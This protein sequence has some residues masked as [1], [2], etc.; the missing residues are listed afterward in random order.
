[1]ADHGLITIKDI[2]QRLGLPESSL[3][4][5]RDAF[6]Q[7][8]PSVGSGRDRRY[9]EEA[10]PVFRA[11][12]ELREERHL[13][14]EDSAAALAEQFPVNAEESAP[15]DPPDAAKPEYIAEI[16]ER[17]ARVERVLRKLI[18][19]V[20]SQHVVINAVGNELMRNK[21]D[22]Q[23]VKGIREDM[24]LMRRLL[25]ANREEDARGGKEAR[26]Q[27][28]TVLDK[29]LE[30]QSALA[31]VTRYVERGAAP[32]PE[33]EI[34]TAGQGESGR[35][36]EELRNR[37]AASR[38]ENDH[39]RNRVAELTAHARHELERAAPAPE[40][41][42][43]RGVTM[44]F[45]KNPKPQPPKPDRRDAGNPSRLPKIAQREEAT[46]IEDATKP[47]GE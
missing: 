46:S 40:P 45:R 9:R 16:V 21:P 44:L 38:R 32:K 14:W 30:M 18:Q 22:A 37:L 13:S 10:V 39:L 43:R 36:L 24:L 4:K 5:Y 34:V 6:A 20:E 29:V 1:M 28:I 33:D 15:D 31:Y 47:R 25:S 2:A 8:I 23:L 27:L 12:R 35:E 42:P 41:A 17:I 7:F 3:R 26:L 11:I 19:L